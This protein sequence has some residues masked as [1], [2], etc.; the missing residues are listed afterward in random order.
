MDC[1]W[2]QWVR[3]LGSWTPGSRSGLNT[4]LRITAD[5]TKNAP[6]RLRGR[7]DEGD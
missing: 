5:T 7:E 2:K 4:L 6:M 1:E 3:V